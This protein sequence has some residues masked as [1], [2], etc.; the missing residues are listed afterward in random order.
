MI[1]PNRSIRILTLVD[2]DKYL[3]YMRICLLP[4]LFQPNNLPK[5][6]ASGRSVEHCIVCHESVQQLIIKMLVGNGGELAGE[7]N[8]NI[9]FHRHEST[10][11][12]PLIW[13]MDKCIKDGSYLMLAM[14]DWFFGDGSIHRM[15]C[16]AAGRDYCVSGLSLRVNDDSFSRDLLATKL[17]ISNQQL[18]DMTF[19]NAHT[20]LRMADVTQDR[21]SS[22]FS[23]MCVQKMDEGLWTIVHRLPNVFLASVTGQDIADF[24]NTNH[25]L[26]HWDWVW[27]SKLIHQGRYR[28]IGSSD[29]FYMAELTTVQG[30]DPK[31]EAGMQWNDDMVNGKGDVHIETNRFFVGTLRGSKG[32]L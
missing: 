18:V 27:P 23:G 20:S 31:I 6:L 24:S 5:V 32:A 16:Y 26:S 1:D 11:L 13:A 29:L 30:N 21:N 22:R 8:Y 7:S 25:G 15:L 14:P 28:Y 19:R 3:D 12:V 17:P 9:T 2:G 4:S 10:Q